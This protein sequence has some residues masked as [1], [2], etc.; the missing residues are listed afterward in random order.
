MSNDASLARAIV[1]IPARALSG[2]RTAMSGAK[3]LVASPL[4]VGERIMSSVALWM[5]LSL[6]VVLLVVP[7]GVAGMYYFNLSQDQTEFNN[8]ERAG[9]A[10]IEPAIQALAAATAGAQ[11]DLEAV[12]DAVA[13]H[14]E[15]GLA[16]AW[17]GI[18][19]RSGNLGDPA[20]RNAVVHDIDG[21]IETVTNES[22]LSL[23]PKLD[24]SYVMSLGV[25]ELP[26]VLVS[27]SDASLPPYGTD[28]AKT[29]TYAIL[30]TRLGEAAQ[31]MSDY[32]EI[33][34]ER[35]SDEAL[36]DDLAP[37]A[38]VANDLRSMSVFMTGSLTYP[39]EINPTASAERISAASPA[40]LGGL[41]RLIAT[42]NDALVNDTRIGIA[43][44]AASLAVA[45][46]WAVAV[47]LLT[48]K[49]VGQ[50]V[51]AM[52]RLAARDL[53]A[54]QVP[55]G[56]DE[57]GRIG[58]ELKTA[59]I[60]LS[61]AF[62]T[63]AVQTE[64]VAGASAQLASTTEVVDGAARDTLTL[65]RETESEVVDVERL[66]SEV[67]ASGL[68]LDAA[69]HE[70]AHG[71]EMVNVSS[72]RVYEEIARAADLAGALGQSSKGIADSVAAITAIASQT[73]L[74]ALNASIEAARAGAAGRGFAVVA[75]EV[76]ALAGQS[77]DASAIIGRVAA[78]QHGEIDTVLDALR[79]AQEAV[80][81]AAHAQEGV[82]A[83]AT[84]QRG[85][86]AT[87][88]DSITGT[89]QATSRITEQAAKVAAE[90][91][92]TARTM[93]DLRS[94]AGELDSISRRL[95]D[96]VGLFRF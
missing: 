82:T 42:R 55:T 35:T 62:R 33:A 20:S 93:V 86:I 63:L 11:P 47:L 28:S 56:S 26:G 15:L 91:D 14:P 81:E 72:Q 45:L 78:D 5:R 73:R 48:R 25:V 58:R 40:I 34:L 53:T 60:D 27:L 46:L 87:I 68:H 31:H 41:D 9:I 43:L 75:A 59:R 29:S 76:E 89:V 3:N 38:S 95:N 12:T 94:A 44:I 71:I 36:E 37:L 19:G 79:R 92:G 10:V 39:K 67:S 1:G 16:D 80:A 70:V 77:R 8:L 13:A 52:S 83:A 65:T 66:L 6:L 88:G 74:L 4:V 84:Q 7:T 64:M 50:L 49:N 90:A 96:Q 54:H 18:A 22:N 51:N 69:T 61:E 2:A 23:D 17:A 85:S 30:A 32:R 57:F 24:S 21:F